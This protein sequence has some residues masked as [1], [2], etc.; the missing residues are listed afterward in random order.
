[1]LPATTFKTPAGVAPVA[2][3]VVVELE[4]NV[5]ISGMPVHVVVP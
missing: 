4:R 2:T 1:L 5:R 3:T